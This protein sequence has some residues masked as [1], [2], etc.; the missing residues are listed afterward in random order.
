MVVT[1]HPD[2]L[3]GYHYRIPDG[4][5]E[6]DGKEVTTARWDLNKKIIPTTFVE[7]EVSED[8]KLIGMNIFYEF[9][10]HNVVSTKRKIDP[11]F[12]L[13]IFTDAMGNK[14]IHV[15]YTRNAGGMYHNCLKKINGLAIISGNK[16]LF[17]GALGEKPM[18]VTNN[19]TFIGD[20]TFYNFVKEQF[21][22]RSASSRE[23]L[24]EAEEVYR[25][26]TEEKHREDHVEFSYDMLGM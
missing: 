8:I 21:G 22:R 4:I 23:L 20:N 6:C 2:K 19:F 7:T 12:T 15:L 10:C 13:R 11:K 1:F 5:F 9:D 3:F 25:L 16:F 17:M 14:M 24:I 18:I 26:M